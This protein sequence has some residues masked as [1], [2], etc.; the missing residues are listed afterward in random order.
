MTWPEFVDWQLF[1]ADHPLPADLA[2]IHHARM[3]STLINVNRGSTTPAV[4]AR[5]Y[6]VLRGP[7]PPKAAPAKRPTVAQQI[8]A[9]LKR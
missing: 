5:D 9:L 2:D 4:Q 3:L 7:Q 6:I 1:V 8:R